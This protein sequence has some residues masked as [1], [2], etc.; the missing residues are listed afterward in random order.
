MPDDMLVQFVDARRLR[1]YLD[2]A[3]HNW[4]K[5]HTTALGLGTTAEVTQASHYVDAF[6]SVR[7]SV[8]GATLLDDKNG[9]PGTR[10]KLC[11]QSAPNHEE[12][13][14]I[15]VA[16]T[17][18]VCRICGTE[19]FAPFTFHFGAEYAHE[20]CLQ[21]EETADERTEADRTQ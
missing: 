6:Q 13:C 11:G 3:I 21:D 4:R 10:C 8:F 17:R 20:P 9:E 7:A 18:N 19:A 5:R 14:G 15:L 2:L 16:R 1:E 12:D